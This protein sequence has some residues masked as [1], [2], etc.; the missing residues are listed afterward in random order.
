MSITLLI[1]L[2]N[3]DDVVGRKK[4]YSSNQ[5]NNSPSNMLW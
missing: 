2:Y 5:K 4:G 1:Y 3:P